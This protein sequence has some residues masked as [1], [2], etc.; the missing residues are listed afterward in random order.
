MKNTLEGMDSRLDEA[1]AQ[2]SDLEDKVE[3]NI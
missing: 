1:K 2:I 3:E